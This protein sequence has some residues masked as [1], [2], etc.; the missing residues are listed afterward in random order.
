M[1]MVL[2]LNISYYHNKILDVMKC[3]KIRLIIIK[4]RLTLGF[5]KKASLKTLGLTRF[6]F[7]RMRT[8]KFPSITVN[9]GFRELR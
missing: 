7:K 3:F 6:E 8:E 9:L 5:L 2:F 4:T 1:I